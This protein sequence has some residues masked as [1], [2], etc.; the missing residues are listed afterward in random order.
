MNLNEIM[1]TN[2]WSVITQQAQVL[3]KS[4][5][6]PHLKNVEQT[7]AVILKGAELG[8]GPMHALSSIYILGGKPCAS[9]ELMLSLVYK[10][11]HGAIINFVIL[12]DDCCQIEAKRPGGIYQT[13][14]FDKKDAERA[15]LLSKAVWRQYPR[16]LM[17]SR[18]VSEMCRSLFPDAISGVSYT[19]EEVSSD[20]RMTDDGEI[21][22]IIESKI[23]TEPKKPGFDPRNSSHM[24]HLTKLI[25]DNNIEETLVQPLI[26]NMIGKSITFFK[27]ALNQAVKDRDIILNDV[28]N[29]I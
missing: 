28:D 2:T 8:V 24:S 10:N 20:I 22:E 29:L 12:T 21:K 14:T 3:F 11:C 5:M 1:S 27:D 16:A 26:S 4:G 7:I 6:F 15:G 13:F 18:A 19:P 25:Q 23:P 17:R 9:A